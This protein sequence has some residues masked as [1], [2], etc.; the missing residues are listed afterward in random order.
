MPRH[1]RAPGPTPRAWQEPSEAVGLRDEEP[2]TPEQHRL[3]KIPMHLL[4]ADPQAFKK[5]RYLTRPT[6]RGL[7][8]HERASALSTRHLAGPLEALLDVVGKYRAAANEISP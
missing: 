2:L 7:N 8:S 5:R 4:G 3:S 1:S 6:G